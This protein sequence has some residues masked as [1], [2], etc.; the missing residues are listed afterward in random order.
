MN[1]NLIVIKDGW[2]KGRD[3]TAGDVLVTWT[4]YKTITHFEDHPGLREHTARVAYSGDW[5]ITIFDDDLYCFIPGL[6]FM[7]MN[8]P[9]AAILARQS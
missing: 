5:G 3:I 6:T 1:T 8:G 2:K 9:V 7:A 4:E